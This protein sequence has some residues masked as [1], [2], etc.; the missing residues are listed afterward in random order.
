VDYEND[1]GVHNHECDEW[2]DGNVNEEC[3]VKEAHLEEECEMLRV[4]ASSCCLG[5]VEYMFP[6]HFGLIHTS[7]TCSPPSPSYRNEF[8]YAP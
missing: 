7:L 2:Y 1:A 5:L 8:F 6:N 4:E 3:I